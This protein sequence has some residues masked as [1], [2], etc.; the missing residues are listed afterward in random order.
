[1]DG[2]FF[3]EGTKSSRCGRYPVLYTP[4]MPQVPPEV[5]SIV[6]QH[7]GFDALRPLQADAINATL[8]GRDALVVLPTGGGKSLC[9]QVPPIVTGR[10]TVV[11]SPLI[12]LMQDQIAGLKLAGVS[13]AALHSHVDEADA[14][15]TRWAAARGE[16]RLLLVAPERLVT[17]SFIAWLR[18]L[19]GGI[20][21]FAIDEA[22]CISQ[23]G[24]DFRPEYRRMAEL[25]SAFP[26][27]PMQ[28]YTATA[29]P[30]VRDDIVAQL[31][32]SNPALLVG[33][34]DRPNLTY[35]VVPREG[36]SRLSRQIADIVRRHQSQASIIYCVSRK[37]TEQ[38]AEE[39]RTL[40]I[41]ARAYHAGLG[42]PQREKIQRAF[43]EERLN[44]IVATVA[45]G[46]GIDRSDVRCVIHAA[47]PQSVEHYQQET[48][49]AGRDGLPAECVLLY[50]GGDAGRWKSILSRPSEDTGEK[51]PEAIAAQHGLL[52]HMQRIAG[53]ALCRHKALSEYFGQLYDK[54]ACEACD[55]CLGERRDA[56]DAETLARKILSCVARVKERF[57]AAHI[58]DVLIGKAT[59]RVR[60]LCHETLSTFGLL[61]GT[62]RPA[63]LSY[64]QQLVDGG[65][66]ERSDDE[67]PVLRLNAASWQ[68]MRG[69][70]DAPKVRLFEPAGSSQR[71]AADRTVARKQQAAVALSHDEL[72]LFEALRTMRRA[73]ADKLA[74]PAY[75]VFSDDTLQQIAAARPS[76]PERLL[77]V[78]GVGQ[79]KLD[80]FGAEV[81][82]CVL[83]ESPRIGL[84]LDAAAGTPADRQR[85]A[86]S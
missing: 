50:G 35:R 8:S 82:A 10:L 33:A 66:L 22:H 62:P 7:W 54:P 69:S 40:G 73:L 51:S 31:R 11:A 30:R 75:V 57:G 17:S 24:H 71:R 4:P 34:F 63:V 77:D 36:G 14:Q 25:R 60:Q 67:F 45:F 21:A 13:A 81:L 26:R 52:E 5:A 28:A 16:L 41:E 32:L 47:M 46:M 3:Q 15:E 6:K 9:Y 83:R 56:A 74:V 37:N 29:T 2:D 85:L 58:A 86:R 64:I 19:P 59:D 79:K 61:A 84:V 38:I 49:R 76:T 72:R 18:G 65:L 42:K 12:A 39:L 70:T 48:G 43:S 44:V 68:V 27:V 53:G 55:I 20:G 23:W 78:R 80:Q 1:M